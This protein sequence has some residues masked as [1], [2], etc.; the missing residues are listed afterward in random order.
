MGKTLAV[1]TAPVV[2]ATAAVGTG[3]WLSSPRP[4][5][6]GPATVPVSTVAVVRTTITSTTQL[7]GTLGYRPADTIIGQLP[8]TITRLAPPGSVITRGRPIFE[9]DGAPVYLFY[10]SR[11]MWRALHDGITS[12]PDVRELERNLVALG[13]GAGLTVDSRFTWETDVAIRTW[14]NATGQPVTGRVDLG[15]VAFVPGS[16]RVLSLAAELGAPTSPGQPVMIGSPPQPNVALQVPVGQAYLVHRGDP[17]VVTLPSGRTAAGR[18]VNVSRVASGTP[19]ASNDG[20]PSTAPNGPPAAIIAAEVALDH[21]SVAVGLDQAPVSVTINAARASG[22]L[23]VPI[24][25]L[26]AL[27]GGGYGVWVDDGAGRHLVAVQPGLFGSALVQITSRA[28]HAGARV[29]VPPS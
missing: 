19:D 16:M 1:T 11:P 21:P 18:V 15:R 22:V 7:S 9:V 24:T 17:V 28:L 25:A 20:Q 29:E 8:G 13:Y 3:W 5:D 2:L 27:A 12:G 4:P 10:G 26:V 14:Q 6:T 23:A